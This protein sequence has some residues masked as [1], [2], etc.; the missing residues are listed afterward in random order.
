[1]PLLVAGQPVRQND[2]LA[3]FTRAHSQFL[4][5]SCAQ[6]RLKPTVNVEPNSALYVHQLEFA[7]VAGD[8]LIDQISASDV[9]T[10]CCL[11][12]RHTGSAATGVGHF[13]END[14]PSSV[15]NLVNLVVRLTRHWCSR[16]GVS[17]LDLA[18]KFRY[19]VSLIGGFLDNRGISEEVCWQILEAL[20]RLPVDMHLKLACI[21]NNNTQ[22]KDSIPYPCTT[23]IVCNVKTGDIIDATVTDFGP[24]EGLRRL[25]FTMRP[26]IEMQSIYDPFQRQLQIRGYESTLCDDTIRQLLGLNTNSFLHFWSTSPLAEKP[27]FVPACKVALK[28]LLENRQAVFDTQKQYNF[29]RLNNQWNSIGDQTIR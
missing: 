25:R 23:S 3:N 20:K 13:D 21:W 28:F 29:V 16:V 22:F 1:M 19:E 10:C 2:E 18:T 9:T 4:A 14:T 24:L 26:P 17:Q 8:D 5:D 15:A 12:V 7:A 6:F 27:S 11:V